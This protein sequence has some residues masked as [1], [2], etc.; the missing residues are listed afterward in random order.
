MNTVGTGRVRGSAVT[1]TERT[2]P[3]RHRR[4]RTHSSTQ[5]AERGVPTAPAG[6]SESRRST[7]AP[8]CSSAGE[9]P[10]PKAPPPSRYL[11][12]PAPR[13]AGADASHNTE[14]AERK[15]PKPGPVP[16]GSLRHEGDFGAPRSGSPARAPLSPLK[17]HF[18]ASGLRQRRRTLEN[19]TSPHVK[20]GFHAV[21]PLVPSPL[22]R[23]TGPAR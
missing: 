7:P 6:F 3:R 1:R 8:Q 5:P 2:T 14:P 20:Q 15:L 11:A 23:R 17:I 19:R 9:E 12:E 4:A 22:G 21:R 13:R 10:T 16:V 18:G